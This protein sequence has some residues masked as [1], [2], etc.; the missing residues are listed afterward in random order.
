MGEG[1]GVEEENRMITAEEG[2][3]KII[4]QLDNIIE[5]AEKDIA[6]TEDADK[7]DEVEILPGFPP[8]IK[9]ELVLLDSDN[10]NTGNSSISL[11]AMK[12]NTDGCQQM[13][14]IPANTHTRMM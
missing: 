7:A 8:S 3:R 2:S 11:P 10:I 5:N 1:D 12:R 13:V 6:P 4:G 9:G 14:Y